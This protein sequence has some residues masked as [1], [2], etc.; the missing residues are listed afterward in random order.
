MI[1]FCVTASAT[2]I[3]EVT[4]ASAA[5]F[6]CSPVLAPNSDSTPCTRLGS[7]AMPRRYFE[8]HTKILHLLS[9]GHNSPLGGLGI[10]QR[11]DGPPRL[12]WG[13]RPLAHSHVPIYGNEPFLRVSTPIIFPKSGNIAPPPAPPWR[14]RSSTSRLESFVFIALALYPVKNLFSTPRN[15]NNQLFYNELEVFC[16]IYVSHIRLIFAY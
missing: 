14:L 7:S 13:W 4:T 9:P 8:F 2:L 10:F 12:L 16:T 5:S 1:C 15:T 11:W 6:F 3:A